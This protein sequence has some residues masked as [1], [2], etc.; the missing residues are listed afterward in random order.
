MISTLL[1]A[2]PVF[3]RR[4]VALLESPRWGS[5]MSKN[6]AVITYVGRRTGRTVRTPIGYTR[7]GDELTILVVAP[8][9]KRWWRNFTGAGGPLSI[10]LDGGQRTGHAV[11]ERQS[12]RR[13]TVTVR[14]APA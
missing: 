6:L 5:R 10:G 2:A 7:H 14:L 1:K 13:A 11:A 9:E 12:S 3:N 4:V 8:D